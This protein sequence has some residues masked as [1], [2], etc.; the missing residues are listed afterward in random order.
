M[1]INTKRN[2][3]SIPQPSTPIKFCRKQGTTVGKTSNYVSKTTT[4]A[5]HL[6]S[7]SKIN[8]NKKPFR[9]LNHHKIKMALTNT[10]LRT[11]LS[12]V[13]NNNQQQEE[14][15]GTGTTKETKIE[16]G[17]HLTLIGVCT[18]VR[19]EKSGT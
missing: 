18:T 11:K 8:S 6:T 9:M 1:V 13:I 15:R 7:F 12:S 16:I 10:N 5:Q 14:D 17:T 2:H 19:P 4:N 3:P